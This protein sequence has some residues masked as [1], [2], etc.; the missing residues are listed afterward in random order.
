LEFLIF[1]SFVVRS[2][3]TR[4]QLILISIQQ[5]AEQKR[6]RELRRK[7]FEKNIFSDH[8]S[9]KSGFGKKNRF[10]SAESTPAAESLTE[11]QFRETGVLHSTRISEIAGSLKVLVEESRQHRA[12]TGEAHRVEQQQAVLKEAREQEKHA[13]WHSW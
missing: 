12:A 13:L 1:E 5:V 4:T 6:F 9:K 11:R 8:Q 2:H 7:K 10:M 3:N